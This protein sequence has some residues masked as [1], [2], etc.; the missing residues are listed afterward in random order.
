MGPRLCL[1]IVGVAF[2]ASAACS[3]SGSAGESAAKDISTLSDGAQ[4]LDADENGDLEELGS[5]CPLVHPWLATP[6]R[7]SCDLPAGTVCSWPAESCSPGQKPDNVCTCID[8]HGDLVFDCVR[9][10]QNCLP[11]EGSDVAPGTM[12]RPLPQHRIAPD[13][14]EATSLPREN[15]T[16][17]SYP[18]FDSPE[19]LCTNDSDCELEGARCLEKWDSAGATQCVCA[20]S[21]CLRDSDCPGLSVCSCGSTDASS[22]CGAQHPSC[23][24][25]CIFSDCRTDA[26]CGGEKLCSPSWD[27]CGWNIKGYH[28]HDPHAAECFSHWE[29]MGQY[30]NWG[31]NFD[32]NSGW[33]CQESPMCD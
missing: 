18:K 6:H 29:C 15:P 20:T 30:G 8:L 13:E 26:D 10:F 11:L 9:P 32:K 25:E 19:D 1:L 27:I 24:H 33:S 12:T 14:C 7:W 31:C 16:C 2:L 23:M 4:A 22:Y 21:E 28:C 5:E 3:D 17:T